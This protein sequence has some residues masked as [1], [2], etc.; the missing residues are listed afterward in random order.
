MKLNGG[1]VEPRY[2]IHLGPKQFGSYSGVDLI[3]GL[4][5]LHSNQI[6]TSRIG[7]Y[8]EV[9]LISG[10]SYN[11]VLLYMNINEQSVFF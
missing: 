2:K 3:T 7:S 11:G 8:N 4:H 1:T 10:G 6:G 9:D 5:L